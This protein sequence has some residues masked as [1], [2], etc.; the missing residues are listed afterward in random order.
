MS[1]ELHIE[2]DHARDVVTICG[3]QYT[4]HLFRELGL[5]ASGSWLR[6]E[7]RRDGVLTIS[8]VATETERLFDLIVGKGAVAGK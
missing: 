1:A 8:N 7:S 2:H 4:G 3:V 5:A 6:I